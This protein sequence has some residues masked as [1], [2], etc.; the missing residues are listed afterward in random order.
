MTEVREVN[1]SGLGQGQ[2]EALV[3]T[4]NV[5]PWGSAPTG[6]QVKIYDITGGAY[7]D[8]SSTM[9]TGAASVADD[10]ITLPELSGLVANHNY[11]LE[12]KF[13]IGDNTFEAWCL[14]KGER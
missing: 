8:T 2:D 3:Y 14:I 9:L 7:T 11:R 1:E 13:T 12:V 4:L 5:S 10:D 6:V